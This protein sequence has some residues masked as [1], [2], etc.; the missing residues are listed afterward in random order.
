MTEEKSG[1]E[2]YQSNSQKDKKPPVPEVE[3]VI[4]VVEGKAIQRKKSFGRRFLENFAPAD[5]HDVGGYV[6]FQVVL[7]RLKD[8][9]FDVGETA[10]RRALWGDS[11]SG[12]RSSGKGGYTPYNT[13]SSSG[14]VNKQTVQAKPT[15]TAASDEFG[16]IVVETRGEAEQVMDSISNKIEKYGVA[17]VS[18]LKAACGL[19]GSF[20]DE[21]FGWDTM[22]GTDIRRVGGQHPGFLLV[23][24]RPQELTS[25]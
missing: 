14:V 12:Y 16:E 1:A 25:G 21:R 17:S 8:L 5:N 13:I 6:F 24:P 19:T 2:K 15:Q 23:F 20:T 3:P 22:G 11:Q 9:I 7:P 18:D 4:K 10:L